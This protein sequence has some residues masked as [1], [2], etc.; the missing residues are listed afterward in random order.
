MNCEKKVS[1]IIPVYNTAEY[2]PK[3]LQSV[4][5]QTYKNLEIICVNDG[6][7]DNSSDLLAEFAATDERLIV[8]NKQ[9]EGVSLARNAGL[10][11]ASGDYF[12]FLDSD[13]WL[14]TDAVEKMLSLA[15]KEGADAV[16]CC[17]AKEF[18]DHTDVSH[19]FGQSFTYREKETLRNVHRSLVGPL[20]DELAVPQNADIMVTPCMQLFKSDSC[21]QH[22]FFDI[23]ELGTFEDGLYQMDVYRNVECF[24]YID[25]PLYH[26]RKD[27]EGSITTVYKADLYDKWQHL[28]DIIEGKIAN[29]N[30]GEEYRSALKNRIAFSMLGI[31]LNETKAPKG[32][33]RKASFLRKI[34][35]TERY[36]AAYKQLPMG[37][38]PLHWKVFFLLAKW[39]MTFCLILMLKLI[40]FLR[41]R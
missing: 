39:R 14:D 10:E 40:E 33:F 35:K 18:S 41:K 21:K 4:F 16:M 11:R 25:E 30:E 26:Y 6:S 24:S 13:D 8:I 32:I 28:F 31:G 3:C 9:N 12:M 5:S 27:N 20:G 17:Y 15:E 29:W 38:F 1:I 22:R 19:I 2:L 36:R 37:Y 7:P 23:R 34:L